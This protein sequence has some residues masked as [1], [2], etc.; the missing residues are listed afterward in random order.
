MYWHCRVKTDV[1]HYSDS[2]NHAIDLNMLP[3][4]QKETDDDNDLLEK[5]NHSEHNKFNKGL[6][7]CTDNI[8]LG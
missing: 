7:D 5:F 2:K 4:Q 1:G 3:T 8:N 6:H